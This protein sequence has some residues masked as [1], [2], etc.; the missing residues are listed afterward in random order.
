MRK[1]RLLKALKLVME[2]KD[3]RDYTEEFIQ[4]WLTGYWTGKDF[5]YEVTEKEIVEAIIELMD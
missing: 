1:E 3:N 4:E 2:K 5:Y